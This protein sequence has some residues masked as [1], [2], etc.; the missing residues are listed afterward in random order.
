M[1]TVF[2]FTIKCILFGI[3]VFSYYSIK[4]GPMLYHDRYKNTIPGREIY[5]AIEKSKK[6]TS[7]KNLIIGDSNANQYF[8]NQEDDDTF[9]SL[10]CNQAIGMVGYYI[11]LHDFLETGN[12]PDSVYVVLRPF[13]LA[14]NLDDGYTYHYFLKPLYTDENIPL[15]TETVKSQVKKIPY[16]WLCHFPSVQTSIWSPK[17]KLEPR[18]Y[19]FLSPISKEYLNKIDSLSHQYNFT[20]KLIPSLLAERWKTTILAFDRSE[21]NGMHQPEM[22]Q[23]YLSMIEYLPDSCYYP[24]MNHVLQPELYRSR[25]LDMMFANK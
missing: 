20:W 14:N 19:S 6:K 7:K 15:M 10:A 17:Q 11:L 8:N 3:I 1:R 2:G 12:R 25:I 22:L 21:I 18:T 9:Y 4:I 16:Y 5:W 23:D 24:D 13:T